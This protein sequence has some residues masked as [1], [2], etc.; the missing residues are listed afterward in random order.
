MKKLILT[1]ALLASFGAMA[2]SHTVYSCGKQY[3]VVA[4]SDFIEDGVHKNII[5]V[6]ENGKTIGGSS[7]VINGNDGL[8]L[9]H[10]AFGYD[11]SI[12]DNEGF[13]NVNNADKREFVFVTR[14]KKSGKGVDMNY[15]LLETHGDQVYDCTEVQGK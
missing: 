8:T 12:L 4:A 15:R 7:E 1:C 3:A 5:G 10:Y 14:I 2:T 9:N 13:H 6:V 11:G